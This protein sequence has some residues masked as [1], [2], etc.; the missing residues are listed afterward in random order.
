M[1]FTVIK[2][3]TATNCSYRRVNKSCILSKP[4]FQDEEVYSGG[5]TRTRGRQ[6]SLNMRT[7]EMVVFLGLWNSSVSLFGSEARKPSLSATKNNTPDANAILLG[8]L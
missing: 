4:C 3:S 5:K 1:Q 6:F 7:N 2:R 8:I